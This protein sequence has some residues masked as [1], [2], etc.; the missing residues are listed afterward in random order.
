MTDSFA[1]VVNGYKLL[2][3]DAKSAILEFFALVLYTSLNIALV[4][5]LLTLFI[6]LRYFNLL[7]W[8]NLTL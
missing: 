3:T 2:T 1:A 8:G 4:S 6:F 5:L 7:L